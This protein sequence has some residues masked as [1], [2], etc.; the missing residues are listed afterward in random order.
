[1]RWQTTDRLKDWITTTAAESLAKSALATASFNEANSLWHRNDRAMDWMTTAASKRLATSISST[2]CDITCRHIHILTADCTRTAAAAS[3][4][5][6]AIRCSSFFRS[7]SITH[8]CIRNTL[9]ILVTAEFSSR[10]SLTY[11]RTNKPRTNDWMHRVAATVV[12]N[13][14]CCLKARIFDWTKIAAILILLYFFFWINVRR[15]HWMFINADIAMAAVFL[16]CS[17]RTSAWN[18]MTPRLK[19]AYFLLTTNARATDWIDDAPK[20]KRLIRFI[21]CIPR[22]VFCM[23]IMQALA[24]R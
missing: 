12:L 13:C 19:L 14:V 9:C 8:W 2:I 4:L 1:M 15:W 24:L 6:E 16:A 18:D 23:S 17:P 21:A 7:R 5:A 22:K 3:L 10:R 20:C 11:L